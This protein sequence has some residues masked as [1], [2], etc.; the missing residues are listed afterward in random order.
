[1]QE[2][3]FVT[4]INLASNANISVRNLKRLQESGKKVQRNWTPCGTNPHRWDSAARTERRRAEAI[5]LWRGS[6]DT[7]Q[8]ELTGN[9]HNQQQPCTR[10]NK[11]FPNPQKETCRKSDKAEKAAPWS[12]RTAPPQRRNLP[13]RWRCLRFGNLLLRRPQHHQNRPSRNP[14]SHHERE[15]HHFSCQP[16]PPRSLAHKGRS[17]GLPIS[18]CRILSVDL[19]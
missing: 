3:I 12:A 17:L 11:I 4:P 2:K 9:L 7:K 19:V 16:P 8:C 1:M 13:H 14:R 5:A 15:G 18:W 6:I 10:E